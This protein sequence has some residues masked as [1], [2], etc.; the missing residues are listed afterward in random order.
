MTLPKRLKGLVKGKPLYTHG[1]WKIYAPS[2]KMLR[3]INRRLKEIKSG[4]SKDVLL[5]LKKDRKKKR[6]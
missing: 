2:A 1:K 6:R 4:K 3:S 5:V